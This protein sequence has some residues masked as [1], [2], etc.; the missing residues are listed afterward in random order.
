MGGGVVDQP[1]RREVEGADT[2][3]TPERPNSPQRAQEAAAAGLEEGAQSA[4]TPDDQRRTDRSLRGARQHAAG[5]VLPVQSPRI[6][7]VGACASNCRVEREEPTPGSEGRKHIDCSVSPFIRLY[8][9]SMYHS[10]TA[11]HP[12]V[13]TCRAC[14]DNIP[15]PVETMPASWIIA[16]CPTCEHH[17]G[18]LPSDIFQGR[19]SPRASGE[20][21]AENGGTW[22]K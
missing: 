7:G 2:A 22:A 3:P 12:F 9:A 18:Y 15:A 17:C 19:L 8:S 13:V 21:S 10:Q 20:R 16:E 1:P 4:F 6:C 14:G 11:L 5:G